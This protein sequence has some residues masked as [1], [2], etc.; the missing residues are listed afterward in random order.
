MEAVRKW[1][2][3]SLSGLEHKIQS[4]CKCS[5]RTFKRWQRVIQR[6]N[7]TLALYNALLALKGALGK[8]TAS[9]NF[10]FQSRQKTQRSFSDGFPS[11][12]VLSEPVN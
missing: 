10:V 4:R 6:G 12:P 9:L 7:N 2:L 8:L 5:Q 11:E 3:C 1:T